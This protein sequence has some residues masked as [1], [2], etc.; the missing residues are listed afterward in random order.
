MKTWVA[1]F[2]RDST[3]PDT[4]MCFEESLFQNATVDSEKNPAVVPLPGN[5]STP[6]HHIFVVDLLGAFSADRRASRS[7]YCFGSRCLGRWFWLEGRSR[8]SDQGWLQRQHRP[9]AGDVL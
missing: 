8:H 2:A 4:E 6:L 7:E 3:E 5:V 1:E 9:R